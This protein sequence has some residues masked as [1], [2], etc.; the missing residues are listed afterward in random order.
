MF[1]APSPQ[2]AATIKPELTI[3]SAIGLFG[4]FVTILFV[5]YAVW[6]GLK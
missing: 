3:W 6:R 1:R 4:V 5:A 2:E